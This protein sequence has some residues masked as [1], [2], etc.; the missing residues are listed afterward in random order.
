MFIAILFFIQS[1]PTLGTKVILTFKNLKIFF[2]NREDR[3]QINIEEFC[4]HSIIYQYHIILLSNSIKFNCSIF[5][6]Y[7]L[8]W[9]L[10]IWTHYERDLLSYLVSVSSL[11]FHLLY[12]HLQIWPHHRT[13]CKNQRGYF[14]RSS[15][16]SLELHFWEF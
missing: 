14:S 13:L 1:L 10:D 4:L 2:L 6:S 3:R 15:S 16:F 8:L 11:S 12:I 7:H 5:G 9:S